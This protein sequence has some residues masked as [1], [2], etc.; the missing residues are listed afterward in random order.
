MMA[1][2]KQC[3]RAAGR[4]RFFDAIFGIIL[5]GLCVLF[6]PIFFLENGFLSRWKVFAY[7]EIAIGMVAVA[8]VI[9]GQRPSVWQCGVLAGTGLFAV[10]L[11]V[12]MLPISI[13]SL[14]AN[15]VGLLGLA[16]FLAGFVLLRNAIACAVRFD[17]GPP[18]VL[19]A[20]LTLLIP[21][22]P[23]AIVRSMITPF[24]VVGS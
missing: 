16:P 24:V 4:W 7:T 14:F 6:D 18:V 21:A 17:F 8:G 12:V 10:T 3:F 19:I 13:L 20:L 15:G 23:D 11:G 9:A 1:D 2:S 5:S 22:V